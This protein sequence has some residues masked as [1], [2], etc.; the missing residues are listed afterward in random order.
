V[1]EPLIYNY[2]IIF[3]SID[4]AVSQRVFLGILFLPIHVHQIATLYIKLFFKMKSDNVMLWPYYQAAS[5]W[6]AFL[7]F[8]LT[9]SL[10][11]STH[12]VYKPADNVTSTL[13]EILL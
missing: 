7:I 3:Y 8:I 6:L 1:G 9:Y 10:F 5:L 4:L 2:L 12:F 13:S 11:I